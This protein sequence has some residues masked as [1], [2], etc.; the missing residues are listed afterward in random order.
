ME[1]VL[2]KMEKITKIFPGVKALEDVDFDVRAGE[3]HAL[4]GENGAGKSTLIKALMGVHEPSSGKIFVE[5]QEVQ[6][7]NPQQA[8][9]LGL[10]AVYQD[11]T[12]APHLS[13]AENFFL[14][15]LPKKAGLV[16]WKKINS[17]T[18]K[19]LTEL[20][21][22]VD[23]KRRIKDLPIAQQEMVTIAKIV[24]EKA[25]IIVFDEPT[26][27][28]ANEEVEVL[29]TLI[30]KLRDHGCGIIYIS[31]RIEEI[32]E[33]G[34]RVTVLK[35]GMLVETVNVAD[36][37]KDDLVR[38][39]VGRD[40]GDMYSIEHFEP[41]ETV[42]E[43]KGLTRK[44]AYED[45][46]LEV[47][48]GEILGMFGL[49]GSGRT[50]IMRGV[51]GADPFDAGEIKVLGKKVHNKSPKQ[52]IDSGVALLPEDRKTQ[53]LSM[54]LS[55]EVNTNLASYSKIS[56]AGVINVNREKERAEYYREQIRIKTPSIKQKVQNLSGGNQQKVV[57]AK[58]LCADSELFIFDECTV[59][60]DVGAKVEIYRLFEQL[61]KQ[62]KAIVL[63]SSYLPEVMG[64]ADRLMVISEGK[65]MATIDRDEFMVDGR[66]DEERIL[67]LASGMV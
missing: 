52:G 39:M 35:D 25:K 14:G 64:L 3:V 11:I 23:P 56:K 16:D 15:E 19:T 38:M 10:G 58:W 44:G 62:G 34:D 37:N 49:V 50:E 59:G 26:A 28:L 46:S 21:I 65:Q 57:I 32:F 41:G 67:R 24:H 20:D 60:V 47:R 30:G 1:N 43:V 4:M 51:F 33:L 48:R 13:V 29:F 36:T 53:G 63:I 54:G 55:V 42:L 27:L 7:K 8:K 12:L 66:L 9:K 61:L 22:K 6:I 17:E 40:V 31:H 45:I 2:V 5:G 18:S